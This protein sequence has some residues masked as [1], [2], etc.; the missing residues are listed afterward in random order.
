MFQSTDNK[1]TLNIVYKLIRLCGAKFTLIPL[2]SLL[3]GLLDAMSIL[4]IGPILTTFNEDWAAK[5]ALV[6][7][8][9]AFVDSIFNML[10]L[11]YSQSNLIVALF[12]LLCF[13]SVFIYLSLLVTSYLRAVLLENLRTE[14]SKAFLKVRYEYFSSKATG[15]YSNIL[16]EQTTRSLQ[17]FYF[18]S[19]ASAYLLLTMAY[20]VLI[21][22][23]SW[24]TSILS[25]TGIIFLFIPFFIINLKLKAWSRKNAA[26]SGEM[27]S[28]F[29]Y[30]TTNFKYLLATQ[31][32]LFLYDKIQVCIQQLKKIQF[33][34]GKFAAMTVAIREPLGV[35][36]LFL[37]FIIFDEYNGLT[38]SEQFIMVVL[39]YRFFNSVV[40]FQSNL[41][42]MN[43][44]VGALETVD[45]EI[46]SL[47]VN[48]E[49]NSKSEFLN[50]AD[51][52]KFKNVS[53]KYPVSKE[54]SIENASFSIGKNQS[55][56]IIGKSGS[57]KSTVCN[58][59]TRLIE[60]NSGFI[61]FDDNDYTN[62]NLQTYRKRIGYVSQET[63]FFNGTILENICMERVY[64]SDNNTKFERAKFLC[65]SLNIHNFIIKQPS[66]Y[67]THVGENGLKLSGGQ[68][69]RICIA[70]ELYRQPEM[71]ILDEATSALD[72]NSRRAIH[73]YFALLKGKLTVL[74]ISHRL[75]NL[76][77]FDKVI[78][79]DDGA[80]VA[81]GHY[82]DLIQ[83]SFI[84]KKYIN[85]LT[86][87][88]KKIFY[89]K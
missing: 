89:K 28:N 51:Q 14:F 26:V 31:Q 43:E 1:T 72:D 68:R 55:V 45:S 81:E 79:I 24:Q 38:G 23:I 60:P 88:P 65:K 76:A 64:S 2:L 7:I 12:V 50:F 73:K 32:T 21:I 10:N 61:F 15:Y 56:V 30:V 40:T 20:S 87:L 33:N 9:D 70:R 69:Q 78:L 49:F 34:N 80:I 17:A 85:N 58:L 27:I 3:S 29:N 53:F 52:I 41:Q 42:L 74:S 16:N 11:T 67:D 47:K 5:N 75:D 82:N 63:A 19:Q 57:G 83:D 25:F 48:V 84:F 62:F 59:L 22:S 37:I 77:D 36:F 13:R 86:D 71:L 18:F 46:E 39:L 66:G 4:L 54:K 8:I 44:N 35:A 6:S